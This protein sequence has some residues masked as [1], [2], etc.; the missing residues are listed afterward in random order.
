MLAPLFFQAILAIVIVLI[1]DISEIIN[2]LGLVA[3]L[4]QALTLGAFF[5]LRHRFHDTHRVVKVPAAIP[6]VALTVSLSMI[7]VPLIDH[8]APEFLLPVAYLSFAF[9]FY[10]PLVYKQKHFAIMG[11]QLLN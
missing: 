6:A 9:L 4:I 5:I 7:L 11:K 3:W 2:S 10:Y 1:Q 8:P